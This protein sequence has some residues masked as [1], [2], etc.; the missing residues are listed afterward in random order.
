M[1]KHLEVSADHAVAIRSV[2]R[3]VGTAWQC[4]ARLAIQ[5]LNGLLGRR[6]TTDPWTASKPVAAI[7]AAASYAVQKIYSCR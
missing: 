4:S 1:Q 7:M 2:G 3:V 5:E 6:G